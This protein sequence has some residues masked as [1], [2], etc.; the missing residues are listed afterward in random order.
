MRRAQAIIAECILYVFAWQMLRDLEGAGGAGPA[1]AVDAAPGDDTSPWLFI[2]W[3]RANALVAWSGEEGKEFVREH[4]ARIV[5][6]VLVGVAPLM[7]VARFYCL[8]SCACN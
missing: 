8:R 3:F 7:Q 4:G 1:T 6:L 2:R 5:T